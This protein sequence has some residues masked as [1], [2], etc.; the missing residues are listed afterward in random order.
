MLQQNFNLRESNKITTVSWCSCHH[1]KEADK[2]LS[3]VVF[4]EAIAV[5]TTA[6]ASTKSHLRLSLKLKVNIDGA[7]DCGCPCHCSGAC[8]PSHHTNLHKGNAVV[9][10]EGLM[11]VSCRLI[12]N[13]RSGM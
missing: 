1:Q 3:R 9:G 10:G 13:V 8:A 4:L 5:E 7:H 11:G 2:I 12:T 6:G